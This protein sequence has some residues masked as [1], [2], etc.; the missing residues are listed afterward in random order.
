MSLDFETHRHRN[1]QRRVA[2]RTAWRADSAVV[3]TFAVTQ[4]PLLGQE[5]TAKVL[6]TA[7]SALHAVRRATRL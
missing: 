3:R 1:G 7:L 4:L 6:T 2:R 5:A